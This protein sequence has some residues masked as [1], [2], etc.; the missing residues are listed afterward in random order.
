MDD[1]IS[2]AIT[3]C[4]LQTRLFRNVLDG[5]EEHWTDS[6]KG[7]NHA[8]W[9]AGHLVSTRHMMANVSGLQIAE[10][11]P[12]L[13]GNGKGL[14]T[15]ANYPGLSTTISHWQGISHKLSPHLRGLSPET[16]ARKAPFATPAGETLADFFTF[17]MHHE[18]YHIGQ[19]GI[20]RRYFGKEAMKYN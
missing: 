13:F 20:L 19:L 6:P 1:R 16:L 15:K 3:Q 12:E 5:M 11:N 17:L 2:S 9:L 18:A 14:E 4:E 8:A 7:A 10:P